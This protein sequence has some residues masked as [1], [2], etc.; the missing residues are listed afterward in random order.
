MQCSA[1]LTST[2]VSISE[3]WFMMGRMVSMLLWSTRS[4]LFPT[5]I[6]GTLQNVTSPFD[7]QNRFTVPQ[8]RRL[9]FSPSLH[10]AEGGSLLFPIPQSLILFRG[11]S[12]KHWNLLFFLGWFWHIMHWWEKTIKLA[13]IKLHPKVYPLYSGKWVGLVLNDIFWCMNPAL[14]NLVFFLVSFFVCL[15]MFCLKHH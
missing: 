5:R 15:F 4:D 11:P 14:H 12:S 1:L 2:Q 13:N 6:R 9:S 7:N 3:Y 10:P 8:K